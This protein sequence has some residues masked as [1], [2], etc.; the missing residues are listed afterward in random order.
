MALEEFL[1]SVP[2]DTLV[3]CR[4]GSVIVNRVPEHYVPHTNDYGSITSLNDIEDIVDSDHGIKV[5]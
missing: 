4:D 2:E 5:V 3:E 1:N